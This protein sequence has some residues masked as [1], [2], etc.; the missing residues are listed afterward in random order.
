[1][2]NTTAYASALA[3]IDAARTF[4]NSRPGFSPA[5]YNSAKSY[6]ADVARAVKQRAA[7]L[8]ELKMLRYGFNAMTAW[9]LL[10]DESLADIVEIA[11]G[12]GWGSI[13]ALQT[14][15]GAYRMEFITGQY[16]PTEYR[17]AALGWVEE[18]LNEIRI[19]N[20]EEGC[21]RVSAQQA[22]ARAEIL[23]T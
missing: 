23:T 3:L 9:E 17:R 20:L 19:R 22:A 8:E 4:V 14:Q 16:Y 15:D 21:R 2:S 6:R 10:T 7:A 18:M 11:N 13:K 5:N 1:M 12:K